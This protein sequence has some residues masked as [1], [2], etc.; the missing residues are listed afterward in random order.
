MGL[1]QWTG[2]HRHAPITSRSMRPI[3]RRYRLHLSSTCKSILH[4]IHSIVSDFIR[5][6]LGDHPNRWDAFHHTINGCTRNTGLKDYCRRRDLRPP[7]RWIHSHVFGF[8]IAPDLGTGSHLLHCFPFHVE[9]HRAVSMSHLESVLLVSTFFF[10][11][12]SSYGLTAGQP[13]ISD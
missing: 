9:K 12:I 3:I 2:Y 6:L 5:A 11:L 7:I 10:I 4:D 1:H 8:G 13:D